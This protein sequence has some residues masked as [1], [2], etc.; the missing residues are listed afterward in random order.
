MAVADNTT[1][2]LVP[3]PEAAVWLPRADMAGVARLELMLTV[4]GVVDVQ[5]LLLLVTANEYTPVAFTP[6]LAVLVPL[7][8]DGPLQVYVTPDAGP[9]FIITVALLHV[10]TGVLLIN[11]TGCNVWVTAVV[12]AELVHELTVLVINKVYVPPPFA[13]ALAVLPPDAIDEPAGATQV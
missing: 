10:I 2:L 6:A 13:L 7:T 12:T 3:Q 5:P 11:A 9:P 8:T 4:A 1:I